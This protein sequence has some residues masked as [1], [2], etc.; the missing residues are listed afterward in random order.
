MAKDKKPYKPIVCRYSGDE[1]QEFWR[2]VN[3]EMKG[4]EQDAAYQMGC[5]LQDLESR[6]VRYINEKR[7][8]EKK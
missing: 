6:V 5:M 4:K 7:V 1:S 3:T 2:I 8:K